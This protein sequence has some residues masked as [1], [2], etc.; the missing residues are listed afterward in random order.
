[1]VGYGNLTVCRH[2]LVLPFPPKSLPSNNKKLFTAEKLPPYR[3]TAQKLPRKNQ[4]IV[5][6][7]K[8]TVISLYRPKNSA[9]SHCRPKNIAISYYRQKI[10]KKL[11]AYKAQ[12]CRLTACVL[13]V[14]WLTQQGT[15][16][17]LGDRVSPWTY[18]FFQVFLVCTRQAHTSRVAGCPL[19]CA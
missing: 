16:D 4:Q 6:R 2:I 19:L 12:P 18:F 17:Q 11:P 10:A 1:M 14:K 15:G 5:Y 3:I 7:R 13:V 9:I 8:I